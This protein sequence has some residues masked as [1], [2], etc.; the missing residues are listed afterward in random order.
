MKVSITRQQQEYK[1]T[2]FQCGLKITEFRKGTANVP[3]SINNV[4]ATLLCPAS[5]S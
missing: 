5:N 1:G 4:K 3:D 2:F